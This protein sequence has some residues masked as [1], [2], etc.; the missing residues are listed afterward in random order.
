[1]LTIILKKRII[2]TSMLITLLTTVTPLL[3]P[4][5]ASENAI[6]YTN[7][8]T[9]YTPLQQ[10]F[11]INLTIIN[12][13]NL[14]HWQL[15]LSYDPSFLNCTSI[16]VPSDNILGYQIIFPTPKIDN[17]KGKISAFCSIDGTSQVN[18]SGTLCQINF[19]SKIPGITCL[20]IVDEMK[21]TGTY[22][23][24]SNNN[25]LPF[26]AIDGTIEIIAQGFQEN[27]FIATQNGIGYSVIIFSNSTV[28][29]FEYNETSKIIK[30]NVTASLGTEG[31][32]SVVIHQQLQNGIF[33]TIINDVPVYHLIHLNETHNFISFKY[34][35]S[36]KVV[37]ILPTIIGDINGDRYVDMKDIYTI[38]LAYASTPENPRW[39]PL[40]DINRDGTV[41]MKDLYQAVLNYS[42]TW[43]P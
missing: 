6:I 10:V 34:N 35:H 9:T 42:K 17:T 5:T 41:D 27:V 3:F 24:D 13:T 1:M 33:A 43:N 39:N 12:V 36:S 16:S 40:A 29:S 7:P 20:S 18:G 22:L 32:T 26:Q 15:S 19:T 8:S 38:V 25:F 31:F 14:H 23:Q 4:V 2:Y 21:W 11:T 30:F 28:T 37:K